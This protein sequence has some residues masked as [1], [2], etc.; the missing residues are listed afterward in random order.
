MLDNK[1]SRTVLQRSLLSHVFEVLWRSALLTAGLTLFNYLFRRETFELAD[2][3]I[4]LVAL[5]F[6]VSIGAFFGLLMAAGRYR[7]GRDDN[8]GD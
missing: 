7:N 8:D 3:W 4:N 1:Q 5:T 6:V 2:V